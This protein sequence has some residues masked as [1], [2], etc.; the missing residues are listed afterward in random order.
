MKLSIV[1][2]AVVHRIDPTP[3]IYAEINRQI[4][5]NPDVEFLALVD[6]GRM[7]I[8]RKMDLLYGMARGAFTCGVADDDMVKDDYVS[9]LVGAITEHPDVDVVSFNHNYYVDGEY[10]AVI[11]ESITLKPSN[12]W[13]QELFTRT[14]SSKCAV[15]TDYCR[16]FTHPDLWH[17]EDV[18]FARWVLPKLEN[19]HYIDRVLYDYLYRGDNKNFRRHMECIG[20]TRRLGS[21]G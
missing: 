1:M 18:A 4:G 19:E 13:E 8:G 6:N 16:P 3:P 17:G 5:D 20:S 21:H 2:P 14:P 12:S 9:T 7:S 15:R 11:K 10:K